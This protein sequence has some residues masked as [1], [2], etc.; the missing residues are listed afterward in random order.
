MLAKLDWYRKGGGVSDRQWRDLLGVLK[1]QA[2]ALDRAYLI[3]WA[4]ELGVR[5]LLR[6]ALN[7]AGLTESGSG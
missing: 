1:I 7:E 4:A 2:D 5:D 3:H 6:R